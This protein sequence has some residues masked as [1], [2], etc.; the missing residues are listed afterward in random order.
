[1]PIA[2]NLESEMNFV[3]I[4]LHCC[5]MRDFH[6]NMRDTP[7]MDRLRRE[8]VFL[9]LGRGQGHHQGDSLNTEI[10]GVWTA[11]YCDSEL[12]EK[13]FKS[14]DRCRFPKTVIE[15]LDEAGYDIFTRI[16]LGS[17]KLG[18]F[19]VGGGLE[20]FWLKD[21]PERLE[22]FFTPRDVEVPPDLAEKHAGAEIPAIPEMLATI[23][24]SK[25]F[26]AYFFIRETHRGWGQTEGLCALEGKPPG[27]WPED[28]F[29]ARKAAPKCA[30]GKPGFA[31]TARPKTWWPSPGIFP[32]HT[33]PVRAH[34]V[35][36]WARSSCLSPKS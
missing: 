19:A 20:R 10:T 30:A 4:C 25:K 7:F 5:D 14:P 16:G 27:S 18:S 3:I 32:P 35:M 26:L 1:M 28:A 24:D 13:G 33:G 9:P 23:G 22:Q 11:R 8:S 12:T 34:D 36:A 31:R 29:C 15:Y 2:L 6:S 17:R 21:K